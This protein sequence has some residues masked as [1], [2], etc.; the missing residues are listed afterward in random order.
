MNEIRTALPGLDTQ[1]SA[2]D[3]DMWDFMVSLGLNPQVIGG[4]VCLSKADILRLCRMVNTKRAAEFENH[5]R[6]QFP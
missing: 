5:I 2:E 6:R 1:L 4:E 3:Q